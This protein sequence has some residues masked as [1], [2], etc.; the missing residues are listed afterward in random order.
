MEGGRFSR[1]IRLLNCRSRLNCSGIK[2]PS[3]WIKWAG[4]AEKARRYQI[5][6][7][8]SQS[9]LLIL[10]NNAT[11]QNSNRSMASQCRYLPVVMTTAVR[12]LAY[13]WPASIHRPDETENNSKINSAIEQYTFNLKTRSNKSGPNPIF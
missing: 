7:W 13:G 4:R 1:Q 8:I 9:H 11:V 12:W 6:L 2:I 10:S 5:V 3:V